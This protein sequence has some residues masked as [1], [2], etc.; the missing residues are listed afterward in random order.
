[1][2][3]LRLPCIFFRPLHG[4][5]SNPGVALNKGEIDNASDP[6]HILGVFFP[7]KPAIKLTMSQDFRFQVDAKT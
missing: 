2:S 6:N 4:F 7:I 5:I 1:M 3:S